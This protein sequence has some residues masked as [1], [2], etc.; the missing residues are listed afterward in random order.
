[1]SA[2]A[3]TDE[4][5][6]VLLSFGKENNFVNWRNFPIDACTSEF[7]FQEIVLENM[8]MSRLYIPRAIVAADYRKCNWLMPEVLASLNN[9]ALIT[10][11]VEAEKDRNKEVRQLRLNAPKFYNQL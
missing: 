3:K 4:P 7:G 10:L 8:E 2:K 5:K 1:M 11:R 9:A 6:F